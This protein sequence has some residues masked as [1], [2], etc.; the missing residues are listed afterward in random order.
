MRLGTDPEVFLQNQNGKLISSIGFIN[1]DKWHPHQI[2]NM[3]KGFTLQEDNVSLEYGI[4]PA[5]SKEEY[6]S[7]IKAVMDRSLDYIKGLSFSKLSCSVF[8]EDQMNHPRAHIFG[9]EPDFNAWTSKANSSPKPTH[10]YMRSAGGHIHVETGL[11]SQD[12]VKAMDLF[13]GVPSVL[14][15]DGTE[16]RSMYGKAGAYRVK[17]YGVEYRTLSNFWIFDK[18]L[19]YWVWEQ[20]EK[21]LSFVSSGK[22]LSD[23]L[24]LKIVECINTSNKQLAS[25]IMEN[26]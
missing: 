12:V 21:A 19:I 5:S 26:Q 4:P 1:A 14:L 2:P 6:A 15:D 25:Q 9:C 10:P 20:T 7:Y 11:C 24:G 16:R 17:P 22:S 3:T 23:E 18:P 8:D 13:L